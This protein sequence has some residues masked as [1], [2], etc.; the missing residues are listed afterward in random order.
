[1][2]LLSAIILLFLVIDPLGNIPMFLCYLGNIEPHRQHR[3]I[4]REL[5]IGLG[6]LI[7]FLFLGHYLLAILNIAQS[8]LGIAGGIILFLIALKMI[9]S[10]SETIFAHDAASEPFIVPLAIP[11]IAGPSSMSTVMLLMA[12][13]PGR[14]MEWLL[15]L[16]SAWGIAV[17]ILEF[18]TPL[19]RILGPRGLN[20]IERLMGLILTTVAVEMFMDGLQQSFLVHP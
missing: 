13:E 20:A 14:W 6:V 17:A 11:L 18:A 1:M 19:S 16:L 4:L 10:G 2:S 7:G 5:G 3:I 12:R 9:F 15:A 8:S